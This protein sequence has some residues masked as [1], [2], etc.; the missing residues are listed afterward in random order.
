MPNKTNGNEKQEEKVIQTNQNVKMNVN[1]K[2][3][4][5]ILIFCINKLEI[6]NRG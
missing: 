6:K 3:K 2:N 1:D 4:S 5:K